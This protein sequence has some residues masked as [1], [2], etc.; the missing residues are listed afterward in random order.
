[1]S[2]GHAEG[3]LDRWR[4]RSAGLSGTVSDRTGALI[5]GVA[6]TLMPVILSSARTQTPNDG[7]TVITNDVG[8]YRFT[9]VEPGAY[10]VTA[11]LPGFRLSER[12]VVVSPDGETDGEVEADFV[13][14]VAGVE[15]SVAVTAVRP[16]A[17]VPLP[18]AAP[19]PPAPIRVGGNV[20]RASLVTRVPPEYPSAM[21]NAGVEGTVVVEATIGEDGSTRSVVATSGPEGL[22]AAAVEA[23]RQWRYTPQMLNGMAIATSTTVT[24][25]FTLTD[26]Q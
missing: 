9:D 13:L 16:P 2:A 14:E 26:P 12:S 4:T 18:P 21:R 7:L 10:R 11:R 20:A 23:V 25:D 15:T 22:R 3:T 17:P 6:V 1:M 5:P 24:V 19:R 8:A